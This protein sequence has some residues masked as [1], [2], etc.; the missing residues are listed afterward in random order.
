MK[1]FLSILLAVICLGFSA[2]E[3]SAQSTLRD[4]DGRTVSAPIAGTTGIYI[5]EF[6]RTPIVAGS[7][8]TS[9]TITAHYVTKDANEKIVYEDVDIIT[10]S[11]S[12]PW[13][14]IGQFSMEGRP[15][16]PTEGSATL[17]VTVVW[18][19]SSAGQDYTSPPE[20]T[21]TYAL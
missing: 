15:G 2:P 1:T 14:V 18:V 8:L 6:E 12:L 4:P 13:E 10:L 7:T 20:V 3:V 16:A 17:T 5:Y 19:Y 21:T 11:S 9:A